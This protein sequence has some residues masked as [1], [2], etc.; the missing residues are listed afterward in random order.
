MTVVST[1]L[2]GIMGEM[3]DELTADPTKVAPGGWD[4]ADASSITEKDRR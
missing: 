1:G 2:G 3:E 4:G